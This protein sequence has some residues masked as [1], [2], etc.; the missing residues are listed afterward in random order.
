MKK[1]IN[2]KLYDT[3]TATKLIHWNNGRSA[4]DAKHVI[5][6][7]YLKKTSEYSEYYLYVEGGALSEYGEHIG[8]CYR[9]AWN[10]TPLTKDEACK[11]AVY[12]CSADRYM[13]LFGEVTE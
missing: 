10:I 4:N 8:N 11:W 13:N 5:M 7:L 1:I 12:H 9:P 6:E 2:G 3:N